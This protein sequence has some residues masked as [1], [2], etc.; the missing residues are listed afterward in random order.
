MPSGISLQAAT[1]NAG[2][3]YVLVPQP[4]EAKPV[5]AQRDTSMLETIES[6]VHFDWGFRS[7][8]DGLIGT[9]WTLEWPWMND[10]N[11]A[12]I[13]EYHE[14]AKETTIVWDPGNT[15]HASGATYDVVIMGLESD[16]EVRTLGYKRKVQLHMAIIQV[17]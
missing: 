17:N 2:A 9:V 13:R 8:G 4:A 7:A 14:L 1:L 16:E 3:A 6:N 11:F 15:E 10:A 12:R 5:S